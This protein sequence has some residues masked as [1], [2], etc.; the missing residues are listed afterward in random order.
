MTHF[1]GKII[2]LLAALS[3]FA[4]TACGINDTIRDSVGATVDVLD[5]MIAELRGTSGNWEQLVRD[6]MEKL[7]ADIQDRV[8][9][10]LQRAI[11]AAGAEFSCRV[12]IIRD[13]LAQD[14]ENIRASLTGQPVRNIPPR[15]CSATPQNIDMARPPSFITFSG[16]NFDS[17]VLVR[18]VTTSSE[19]T[20]A[21]NHVTRNSHYNVTV[22]LSGSGLR[23][24]L[25]ALRLV[26]RWRDQ[27]LGAAAIAQPVCQERQVFINAFD[28]SYQPPHT[29]GDR[30]FD[31]NG[32]RVIV[33]TTLFN[34]RSGV[35]YTIYMKAEEWKNGRPKDDFTTAEGTSPRRRV[36]YSPPN[37]WEIIR[38]NTSN[39]A[40]FSH[41]LSGH[42]THRLPGI[43]PV[44]EFEFVGDT[45]GD[46]AGSRTRVTVQFDRIDIII[47]QNSNCVNR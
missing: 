20:V 35:E 33:R 24:G 12:D 17:D 4:L 15:F 46:E 28:A 41:V 2:T 18:L 9:T 25:N 45:D 21:S 40:T 22:N 13:M 14:I 36:N 37:G 34:M 7:P 39:R 11:S 47:R 29:R 27:E 23:L 19:A 16:Y 42:G 44:R 26:L 1:R 3:I 8:D 38:I 6:A 32:P 10:S 30:N 31:S 5:D 43:A